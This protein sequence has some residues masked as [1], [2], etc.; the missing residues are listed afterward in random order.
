MILIKTDKGYFNLED[1][2]GNLIG[3]SYDF[4]SSVGETL[5]KLSKENCL[6]IERGYNVHDL[7]FDFSWNRQSDP[8]HGD[9][10]ELFEAGFNEAINIIG[11]KKYTEDDVKEALNRL[12]LAFH[13]GYSREKDVDFQEADKIIHSLN[14]NKWEVEIVTLVDMGS[15]DADSTHPQALLGTNTGIPAEDENGCIRLIKKPKR[16]EL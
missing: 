12:C 9:T 2:R 13:K 16:Y 5:L 6:E 8:N 15:F 14:E 3:T 1:E 10:I 4:K 7:S 11:D